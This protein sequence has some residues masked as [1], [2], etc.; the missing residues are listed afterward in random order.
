MRVSDWPASAARYA[1][2][3]EARPVV[4]IDDGLELRA[5]IDPA[6]P[7]LEVFFAGYDQ[8]FVLPSEKEEIDGFRDCL[9]LNLPPAYQPLAARHGPFRE[10][11]AVA[12]D[13]T[14]AAETVVGGA[15]LFC[16]PLCMATG[17]D[18]LAMNLNYIFVPP[19]QRRRGYFGR[20]LRACEA[21]ARRAFVASDGAPD[22]AGL[23]LA[24]FL[25][26]NDPLRL[27][28]D[29]YARDTAHAGLDQLQ[30]IAIW[31]RAGTR[32]I[33]FPY[34]QPPLS[35]TQ[36]ADR[37]LLLAVRGIDARQLSACLLREHLSRFFAIS[38]LKGGD[39]AGNP[40]AHAQLRRLDELCGAGSGIPLL[41]A[42]ALIAD[43]IGAAPS[44]VPLESD[45][46]RD[47]LRR[48]A[49]P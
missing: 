46:L 20:I 26:L 19:T 29:D 23:P 36:A 37:N 5:A 34:V 44:G 47:A 6:D 12:V 2:A 32:I 48:H 24:M 1:I 27:D 35:A 30:R 22:T 11:V 28:A 25:E 3:P 45:N 15:N 16:Y 21:L 43:Q 8:A 42:R 17:V 13:T 41:D 39:P 33:N 18:L 4:R 49:S 38:V 40:E 9:A 10:F 31:V 7:L 14:D